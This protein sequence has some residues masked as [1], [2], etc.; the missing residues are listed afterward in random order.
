[1]QAAT[2]PDRGDL[3]Y[4]NFTPQAGHEQ[5]GHRPAIVIS[6]KEFNQN[7]FALLAPIT[8]QE[9]GW[10][11]EVKLPA[12][13]D[14]EGVILTDQ[15]KSLDWR[16]RGL[17]VRDKAPDDIIEECLAKIATFAQ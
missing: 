10:G 5:R 2:T 9:K 15:I 3:V 14:I 16:A 12:G 8:S 11:F 17:S 6:P 4:I 7:G 13:K 1:M